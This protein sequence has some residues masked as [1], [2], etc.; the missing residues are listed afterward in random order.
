[1]AKPDGLKRTRK[2]QRGSADHHLAN[3][4]RKDRQVDESQRIKTEE[5][6]RMERELAMRQP[7]ELQKKKRGKIF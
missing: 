1:M 3:V 6:A 4:P 7:T 2:S 5:L